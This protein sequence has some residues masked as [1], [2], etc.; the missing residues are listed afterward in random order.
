MVTNTLVHPDEI[1]LIIEKAMLELQILEVNDH[2]KRFHQLTCPQAK[3]I[4]A[5]KIIDLSF[6]FEQELL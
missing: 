4:I 5:A 1:F 3:K 6:S 2:I